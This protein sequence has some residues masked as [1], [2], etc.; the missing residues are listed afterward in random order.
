MYVEK[1]RNEAI[2]S[3]AVILAEIKRCLDTLVLK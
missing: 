3:K 1:S 2:V